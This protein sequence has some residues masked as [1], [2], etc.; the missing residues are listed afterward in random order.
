[1][2][3]AITPRFR[4]DGLVLLTPS[5]IR[6]TP[7]GRSFIRNLAMLFDP[8]PDTQHLA[9]K[10]LFSKTLLSLCPALH[11]EYSTRSLSGLEIDI[12]RDM[13]SF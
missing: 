8:Y 7:L 6:T 3:L 9:S 13:I 5:E 12:A 4:D 10:S 2:R 1:M 11:K